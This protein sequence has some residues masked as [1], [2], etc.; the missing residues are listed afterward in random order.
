MNERT[1][2]PR[3]AAKQDRRR[4]VK[5]APPAARIPRLPPRHKEAVKRRIYIGLETAIAALFVAPLAL[6]IILSIL[7]DLRYA[8]LNNKKLASAINF[9]V[10][11]DPGPPPPPNAMWLERL[12]T[13]DV[14]FAELPNRPKNRKGC[15]YDGAVR[16]SRIGKVEVMNGAIATWP[17]AVDLE[18]W[19]RTE[20][21]PNAKQLFGQEVVR[22][23][24]T[25]SYECRFTRPRVLSQ[26]A[27]ANAIDI[28]G[29]WLADGRRI[30]V[31]RD[32]KTNG[33]FAEFLH[34]LGAASCRIFS[35]ALTPDHDYQHRHHFHLD[36][37]RRHFCGYNGKKHRR[38]LVS[39]QAS[40]K[41]RPA[42]ASR[43]LAKAAR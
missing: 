36:A 30:R 8:V 12:K 17:L 32:W 39:S 5:V 21:Q 38:F 27:Y 33:A 10:F 9:F 16:L 3:D 19:I 6:V 43:E 11:D 22:M 42:L 20:V 15:G 41:R 24:V 1:P 14:A 29:F 23:R 13:L 40:G 37:G 26:H 7:P 28:T 31:V 2:K 18:E 34:R 35:V 25:S 4:T